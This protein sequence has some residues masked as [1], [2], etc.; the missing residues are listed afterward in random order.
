M[1]R[2]RT[3]MRKIRDII[4]LHFDCKMSANQ[5]AG[6]LGVARSVVQEC[7][8]K[9]NAQGLTW[10]LPEELDDFQLERL[11][12][13]A[14]KAADYSAHPDWSYIHQELRKKGVTRELLWLEYKESKQIGGTAIISYPQFCRIYKMWCKKLNLVM[15]QDHNAGEKLF[16]DYAGPTIPVV[17]ADTGEVKPSQLF[18]AVLG[19]RPATTELPSSP[20]AHTNQKI[21]LKLKKVC[22]LPKLGLSLPC[23]ILLSLAS[24][25]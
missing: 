16:V 17:D 10:P 25:N 2:E 12:Y 9:V 20:L 18:V 1:S 7:L 24:P 6:N 13:S 11:L 8:R 22:N 19:A 14:P 5:V 3:D 4:R 23:A 21:K 15:R